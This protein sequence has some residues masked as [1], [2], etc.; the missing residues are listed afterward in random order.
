MFPDSEQT[1]VVFV[2]KLS[3]GEP[4]ARAK[5]L[6][7]LHDFIKERSNNKSLTEETFNRLSKGLHYAMWMQDKPIL[8]EELADNIVTIFDDFKTLQEGALFVDVFMQALSKEWHMV[9][10]W[11]IDKFLMFIRRIVRK[12][13][14]MMNENNFKDDVVEILMKPLI[15]NMM[16]GQSKVVDVLKSHFASIYWDE[17]SKFQL[18]KELAH[19]FLDYYFEILKE[20]R[21]TD[22]YFRNLCN[23]I[24]QMLIDTA[25]YQIKKQ[26]IGEEADELVDDVLRLKNPIPLDFNVVASTLFEIGA[27]PTIN[28]TRRTILYNLSKQF[29]VAIRGKDPK[30]KPMVVEEH[31]TV[32]EEMVV[33]AAKRL[34]ET[35]EKASEERRRRKLEMKNFKRSNPLAPSDVLASLL[36]Q[37]AQEKKNKKEKNKF[38]LNKAINK[39]GHSTHKSVKSKRGR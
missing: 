6:R 24:F 37:K 15:K 5:A 36:K 18:S 31:E 30:P 27:R 26:T 1:E 13:F 22:F 34:L 32:P 35:E 14:K 8:Q 33:E 17:L 29:E 20:N 19:K 10:Q 39:K 28:R 25:S 23:E 7:L 38:K 21:T 3:S 9:D 12:I 11:R 2:H 16:S 4:K